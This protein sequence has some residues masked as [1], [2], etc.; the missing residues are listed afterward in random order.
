MP[1]RCFDAVADVS[2]MQQI[3]IFDAQRRWA[4]AMQSVAKGKLEI[5]E[6]SAGDSGS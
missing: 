3:P 5:A 1:A 4:D 2:K 6:M